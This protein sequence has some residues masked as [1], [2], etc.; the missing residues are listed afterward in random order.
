MT[1][2]YLDTYEPRSGEYTRQ[3]A[4]GLAE[5]VRVLD[6]HTMDAEA[7]PYPS[8]IY[9]VLGSLHAA[10]AGLDQLLRQL[11]ARLAAQA[12]SG[13]LADTR[14]DARNS[15]A[16]ARHGVAAARRAAAQLTDHLNYAFQATSSLYLR[17]DGGQ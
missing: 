9:D 16:R 17:E 2:L 13:R 12:T 6:H 8:T 4:A 1:D 11:D 10:T 14:D 7:L 15:A 3:V 5:C